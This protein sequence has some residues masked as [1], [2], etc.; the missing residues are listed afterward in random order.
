MRASIVVQC[1]DALCRFHLWTVLDFE[2]VRGVNL[3]KHVEKL[4]MVFKTYSSKDLQ[5]ILRNRN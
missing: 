3:F 2:S 4:L 5:A 1:N